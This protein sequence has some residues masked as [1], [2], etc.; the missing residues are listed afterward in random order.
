MKIV[1]IGD[2]HGR[3]IWK[4]IVQKEEYNHL[5]FIGDYFDS[6]DISPKSQIENFRDIMT[7]KKKSKKVTCLIGNH[8]YHYVYSHQRYS[9]FQ[10]NHS[11]IIGEILKENIHNLQMSHMIL[12][13]LF[14]HAGVSKEWCK[15]YKIDTTSIDNINL[16]INDQF[17]YKPNSFEHNGY[18]P[19][20][21]HPQSSPIWIRPNSLIFSG[22]DYT[23]IVGHTNDYIRSYKDKIYFIDSLPQYLVIEDDLFYYKTI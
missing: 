20:G 2:I 3:D 18:D 14:T 12:N 15:K 11:I 7:Y 19:Y 9:G 23:Q 13:Y 8:D 6:Y 5:V 10:F 4:K 17:K 16:G 21:D 1:A 22:V